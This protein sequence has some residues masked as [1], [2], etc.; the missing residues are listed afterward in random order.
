MCKRA[1]ERC[2]VGPFEGSVLQHCQCITATTTVWLTNLVEQKDDFLIC[3]RAPDKA[4]HIQAATAERVSSIQHFN[5]HI[6]SINHLH[7]LLVESPPTAICRRSNSQLRH[8]GYHVIAVG[9]LHMAIVSFL[10]LFFRKESPLE[11]SGY[12]QSQRSPG[13]HNLMS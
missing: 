1:R 4:L 12:P 8:T 2:H 11:C 9:C 13:S 10:Q 5:N 7:E 6:S 3:S